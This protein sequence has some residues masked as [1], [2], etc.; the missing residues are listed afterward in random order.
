[1]SALASGG[2]YNRLPY[3]RIE[4]NPSLFIDPI[5]CPP[6]VIL[7]DPQNMP[8][9]DIKTFLSH[10]KDREIAVGP[11]D[12]FRFSKY[13]HKTGPRDSVYV[14][15][16]QSVIG[17]PTETIIH[18]NRAEILVQSSLQAAEPLAAVT[19]P[20]VADWHA[21]PA[22]FGSDI[23][24]NV[25]IT[26]NDKTLQ[27]VVRKNVRAEVQAAR[28]LG[29]AEPY[30]AADNTLAIIS[31]T[32]MAKLNQTGIPTPIATNGPLNGMPKY[33]MPHGEATYYSNKDLKITVPRT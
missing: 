32:E 25:H 9:K 15:P 21:A 33:H 19:N 3:T 18:D 23:A 27:N 1:M 31:Q 29:V 22:A 17:R 20:M 4:K 7:K 30:A 10:I 6:A 28:P 2:K 11:T 5:Y 24:A 13:W 26:N 16:M 12:A 14:A 8:M